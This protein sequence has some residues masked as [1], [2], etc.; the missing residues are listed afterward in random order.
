MKSKIKATL[1]NKKLLYWI[2]GIIIAGILFLLLL[3]KVVMPAYTNYNEGLTVPN[4]SQL[5]LDDAQKKLT[6]Y[7]LRY[8]VAD[9]RSNE[10]YPANYVIDQTPAAAK[11]V[12][13]DRKVYLTVNTEANPTVAVPKVVGLSKRNAIIQLQNSGLKVGTIS[14]E[15]SR[16][17]SSVLRQSAPPQTVVPEGT[18]IDLTVSDGLGEKM[19]IIPDLKGLQLAEGQQKLKELGLR[20]E[21]IKF[22]PTSGV[23]PNT[24]LEYRPNRDRLLEGETLILIVSEQTGEAEQS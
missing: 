23:A 8:E 3:D 19:V 5:S 11:I 4:V 6:E 1:I 14:K 16:F 7:G 24:I 17:K 18:V 12:K 21:E 13:P 9:R 10:A 15:S 20:V 2:G 22:R